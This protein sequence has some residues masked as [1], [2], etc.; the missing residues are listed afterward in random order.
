M[1]LL[2]RIAAFESLRGR[3]AIPEGLPAESCPCCGYPTLRT[4]QCYEICVLCFWEDDLDGPRF[5]S[6]QGV[7]ANGMYSFDEGRANCAKYLTKYGP[8]DRKGTIEY[9]YP[10]RSIRR[11]VAYIFDQV[12]EGEL[13]ANALS[14]ASVAIRELERSRDAFSERFVDVGL[15]DG[16]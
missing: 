6:E 2:E 10:I 1:T 4:A 7:G 8:N 12:A 11:I 9:F 14:T 5:S 3:G 15:H 16:R 13:P